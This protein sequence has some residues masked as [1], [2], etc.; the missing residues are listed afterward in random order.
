MKGQE[1]YYAKKKSEN[2]RRHTQSIG[3]STV[4]GV[5]LGLGMLEFVDWQLTEGI[6]SGERTLRQRAEQ[7]EWKGYLAMA[8]FEKIAKSYP[9]PNDIQSEWGLMDIASRI[10]AGI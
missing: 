3:F 1:I 6:S 8:R 5:L 7:D 2:A 10:R 4:L 9:Y